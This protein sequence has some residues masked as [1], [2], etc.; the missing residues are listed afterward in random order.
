M[1]W[2]VHWEVSHQAAEDVVCGGRID[3]RACQYQDRLADVQVLIGWVVR[4]QASKDPS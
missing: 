2:S 3:G 1:E 4:R